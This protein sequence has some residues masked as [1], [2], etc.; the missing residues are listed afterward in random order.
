[1]ATAADRFLT[2]FNEMK[3]S[4]MNFETSRNCRRNMLMILLFWLVYVSTFVV[5]SLNSNA[6]PLME[7]V[8]N[9][10]CLL[11]NSVDTGVICSTTL[12]V[13]N[14]KTK[15]LDERFKYFASIS[16][17]PTNYSS[18]GKFIESFT[19]NGKQI[20]G[21][22]SCSP[23]GDCSS[24]DYYICY[25]DDVS[26]TL[27]SNGSVH[28]SSR[29]SE[30]VFSPCYNCAEGLTVPCRI[31]ELNYEIFQVQLGSTSPHPSIKQAQHSSNKFDIEVRAE[32][33]RISSISHA[34]FK[35]EVLFPDT[36]TPCTD[37]GLTCSVSKA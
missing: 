8:A 30:Q 31:L 26:Q 34:F 7:L 27:S 11:D 3:V 12:T 5:N 24:G 4:S 25:F 29:S 18:N 15:V 28:I 21:N 16:V 35:F 19:F 23:V 33:S 20:L 17:V 36:E 37:C 14:F 1:M 2:I 9:H 22:S 32:P 13:P 6:F 10:S